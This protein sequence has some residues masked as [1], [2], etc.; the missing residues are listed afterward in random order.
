[1]D[2]RLTNPHLVHLPNF[3]HYLFQGGP[4]LIET[5]SIHYHLGGEANPFE[6]IVWRELVMALLAE[7][8]LFCLGFVDSLPIAHHF[9]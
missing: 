3:L 6:S 4:F 5:N 9:L 7:K 1:M 2:S 8:G